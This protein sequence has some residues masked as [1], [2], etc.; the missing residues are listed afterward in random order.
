MTDRHD[1][2]RSAASSESYE[3]IQEAV[4][5]AE[6]RAAWKMADARTH[7]LSQLYRSLKDDVRY[8][9]TYKSEQAWEA[10]ERALPHIS[11][12]KEK[13]RSLLAKEAEHHE[14]MS[15]PRPKGEMLR[16]G[17]AERLLAAQNQA[18]RV[19]RMADRLEKRSEGSPIGKPS[20]SQLLGDEYAR[21]IKV[22]GVEGATSCKGVL[23]AAEE[24]GVDPDSFLDG[25][26][27]DTHRA[28]QD[29]ARRYS[30]MAQSIAKGVPEP[31]FPKPGVTT[32]RGS[33]AGSRSKGVFQ[34]PHG[35]QASTRFDGGP[36]GVRR[37]PAWK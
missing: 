32:T 17:S 4:P 14:K 30:Q 13:A 3:Q 9:S 23:M 18:A 26:R 33:I 27:D 22:G 19:V 31:P 2:L 15:I 35:E 8:T 6:A 21:G 10:Y 20:L 16:I 34:Q 29:K 25:L 24:L 1:S 37:K 28:Y 36:F 11:E 5:N 7:Q 12:G